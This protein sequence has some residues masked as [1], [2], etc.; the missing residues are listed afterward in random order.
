MTQT[1]SSIN[2]LSVAA[3]TSAGATRDIKR[4]EQSSEH[5][6]RSTEEPRDPAWAKI[7]ANIRQLMDE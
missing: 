5:S 2:L 4:D 1:E 6:Q 7:F 3:E